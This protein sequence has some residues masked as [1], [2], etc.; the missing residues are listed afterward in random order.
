MRGMRLAHSTQLLDVSQCSGE[1]LGLFVA[2]QRTTVVFA[3]GRHLNS[4][5]SQHGALGRIER[6]VRT[7]IKAFTL[8]MI[9]GVT[10]L[11]V[12]TIDRTEVNMTHHRRMT[13]INTQLDVNR[14]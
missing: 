8:V 10:G 1:W 5:Q 11:A 14:H 2:T 6:E 4:T 7:Q 13:A 12:T 9:T 3:S